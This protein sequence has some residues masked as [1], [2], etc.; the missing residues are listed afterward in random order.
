MK[1]IIIILFFIVSVCQGQIYSCWRLI[2]NST[3]A[4]GINNGTDHTI[5]YQTG[6]GAYFA[7]TVNNYIEI[8]TNQAAYN[9]ANT[10]F[11]VSCWIKTTYNTGTEVIIAK[12]GQSV[13]PNGGGWTMYW[14]GS[15]GG[16]KY[17]ASIRNNTSA[18]GTYQYSNT[19]LG[20][21]KW[22]NTT[23]VYTTST[24]VIANNIIV[25]YCDGSIVSS[26]TA[27]NTDVYATTTNNLQ[28][29]RR[30]ANLNFLG[31]IREIKIWSRGLSAAEIKNEYILGKIGFQ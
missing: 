3:D 9:Y 1:T 20:D 19:M 2:G 29:G 17:A 28:I 7:G 13:N 16:A 15:T 31:N 5:T 12:G 18:G 6:A 21:G 30:V 24:T 10:T 27:L 25:M 4:E 14:D 23:V 26:I 22:H 11:T 8:T